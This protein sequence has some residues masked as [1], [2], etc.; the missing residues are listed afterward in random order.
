MKNR[1]YAD[2]REIAKRRQLAAAPTACPFGKHRG[3]AWKLV[4]APYLRWLLT[5]D[6]RPGTRAAIREE[7]ARRDRKGRGRRGAA[8]PR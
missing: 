6:L 7:L 2:A 8:R 3:K 4:P 1:E 5:I